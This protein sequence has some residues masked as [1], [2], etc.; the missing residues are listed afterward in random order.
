VTFASVLKRLRLEAGLTQEALAERA[1]VS[2]RAISD[3]ERDSRRTPRLD[4]VK[5]LADALGL[6]DAQ[7][8]RLL[9]AARPPA[10]A[11]ALLKPLTPLIGR[12]G[13]TA[14]LSELLQRDGVRLLTVTG[15]GGVGKTRL[16]MEVAAQLEP[17]YTDGLL[18]IDLAPLRDSR[19]VLPAIAAQLG[20]DDRD[21]TP[22]PQRLAGAL[23]HRRMLLVIDNFE[24]VIEARGE[25]VQLMSQVAHLQ[26]LITSRVPLR[27]RG[28]R[29]YRLAPLELAPAV[30]LFTE[31]AR[32]IG[33]EL[34]PDTGESIAEICRRLEG[35]PL[36]IEL[37][38]ARLRVLSPDSLLNRLSPRLPLLTG[39]PHDLPDRQKTMRDAVDWSYQL[40]SQAEQEL[41]R[42][43]C[44]F[45]G[46]C[47][48]DA[49][50]TPSTMDILTGIT[51]SSL[52]N[53]VAERLSILE[54]IRE[55]GLEMLQAVGEADSAYLRH[56]DYFAMLAESA[57]SSSILE[58]E[59]D[60]LRVALQWSLAHSERALAA[61]IAGA[62]WP[63]WLER[64]HL[65]EGRRWLGSILEGGATA[66][67]YTGAARLAIEQSDFDAAGALAQE[68]FGLAREPA[69]LAA[70]LTTRGMLAR[71]QDRYADAVRD[72]EAALALAPEAQARAQIMLELTFCAYFTGDFTTAQ[73][74]GT[75][76]LRLM[77]ESGSPR[78]LANALTVLGWL[79]QQGDLK[80]AEALGLEA[81]EIFERLQDTGGTADT[82][83]QL[84][85]IA[86]ID[87]R[88]DRAIELHQRS[89]DLYRDRGD[90]R[91]AAMLLAHLSHS[92]MHLGDYDRARRLGLDSLEPARRY[93]DQWSAAMALL[94]LGHT[95]LAAQQIEA[96]RGYLAEAASIFDAIGNTIYLSWCLEGLAGVAV[97]DDRLGLAAQLCGARDGL[98][99]RLSSHL[100]PCNPPVFAQILAAAGTT[101][102]QAPLAE[103][104]KQACTN[105]E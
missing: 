4:T 100:P 93:E 21:T 80:R 68:A 8:T 105:S 72:Q 9:A 13:T 12:A 23:R 27:V 29:E 63:F 61:R 48:L 65:S 52:V 70:A 95:E 50:I 82:L 24:H 71:H 60:N 54:T 96:A 7:R 55:F 58:H 15:P 47:P 42:Y 66:Q 5:L 44:V 97:A 86:Q 16:A 64:G 92:A 40:L 78:G 22:L 98:L 3:L 18:L 85:A 38:V 17:D 87:G 26:I 37:A 30:G 88:F 75:E 89:Y 46:G 90:E 33:V 59:H 53:V 6:D 25:V 51:E 45:A 67:V 10:P 19:L 1:R 69:D 57:A 74:Y 84:G 79:E 73:A 62:L 81:L 94:M 36:A 49:I 99:E 91:T 77:R 14:A 39:G 43:L 11:S 2:P 28:E 35:L 104:I 32:D 34:T 103:L 76:A 83:R 56:A 41:F 101:A 102:P 31:R 20:L